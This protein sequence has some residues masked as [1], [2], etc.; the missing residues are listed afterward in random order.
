MVYEGRCG[1]AE[2][3]DHRDRGAV[4]TEYA[5]LVVLIAVIL[6]CLV[7]TIPGPLANGLSGTICRIFGGSCPTNQNNAKPRNYLPVFCDAESDEDESRFELDIKF[8][9][10]GDKFSVLHEKLSNGQ[11]WL[12]I[13]PVDYDL[14]GQY[15]FGTD[16]AKVDV[17]SAQ[18]F[19]MGDTYAFESDAQANKFIDQLKT[20]EKRKNPVYWVVPSTWTHNASPKL[21]GDGKPAITQKEIG[22]SYMAQADANLSPTKAVNRP[23]KNGKGTYSI[24]IG[25]GA[26]VDVEATANYEHWHLADPAHPGKYTNSHSFTYKLRGSYD[27]H[28]QAGVSGGG[29]AANVRAGHAQK[30]TGAVRYLYGDDGKL[31]SIRWYTIY[32]KANYAGVKAGTAKNEPN[33]PSKP[34]RHRKNLKE[35]SSTLDPGAGLNGEKS[36]TIT[37]MT[38]IDFKNPEERRIGENYIH[39]HGAVPPL[40]LENMITGKTNAVTN[41]PAPNAGPMTKL[42]YQ[43]GKSWDWVSDNSQVRTDLVNTQFL[44]AALLREEKYTK[45]SEY[46]GPPKNG[47]RSYVPFKACTYG[48]APKSHDKKLDG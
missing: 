8:V 11:V 42:M 48:H 39:E 12:T 27:L 34:G 2:R 9:H 47:H 40:P 28:G 26:Q 14:G 31:Q 41:A 10:F 37:R 33:E 25:A 16:R 45:N 29:A 20:R 19:R 24:N 6:F 15:E 36:K 7:S 35:N 17:G 30:W 38:E 3:D 21:P 5:A 43:N 1:S 32:N 13:V 23:R 44:D 18:H 46:L 4:F 22:Q